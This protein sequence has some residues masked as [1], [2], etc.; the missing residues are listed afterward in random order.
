MSYRPNNDNVYTIGTLVYARENPEQ[1]LV[2]KQYNQ[3]IYYC[4]R[5]SKP[6]EK[7]LAYFE[8]EIIPPTK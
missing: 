1:Q 6:M 8:R 2:I 7:D 5:V 3:R 4:S